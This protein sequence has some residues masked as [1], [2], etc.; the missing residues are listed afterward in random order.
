LDAARQ[1]KVV[2]DQAYLHEH[3]EWFKPYVAGYYAVTILGERDI[4]RP[5]VEAR[6]DELLSVGQPW[7]RPST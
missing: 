7:L 2:M 4:T 6:L 5:E 1:A 3:T